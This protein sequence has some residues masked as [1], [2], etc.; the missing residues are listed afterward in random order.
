MSVIPAAY[1]FVQVNIDTSGLQPVA[2][3]SPGVI[4]IVGDTGGAGAA[5]ANTPTRVDTREDAATAFATVGPSGAVTTSTPLY[6]ALAIAMLQD[7][8]PSKIYGVRV[9]GGDYAAALAALDAA[10][11]VTFVSLAGVVAKAGAGGVDEVTLLK[12]HC[13]A[14]SAAGQRRIGVACV[15]PTIAKSA[16]YVA[17]VI[18]LAAP[19]KSDTSRL[20]LIAA[21]G[22]NDGSGGA[23]D[24]AAAAMA[25]IAGYPPHV[26]MVLKRIVGFKLPV[27]QQYSPAE[28]GQLSEAN[29]IPIIDPALIVGESL[30]FADGRCFTADANLTFIDIVRTLDDVEF[31]LKAGL[32]GA[33]GDA[34]ITRSGLVSVVTRCDGILSPLQSR[35]VI[36]GYSISIPVLDILKVPEAARTA[37]ETA[38]VAA[39][40]ANRVVDV[41]VSI[42]LGPA[43]H[44]LV[45][46]LQP[47]F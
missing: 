19:A 1:P 8:K 34:R 29:I 47:K 44:R 43:V 9:A 15:D 37:G 35:A 7:P 45:I 25:A 3:R 39:A 40:R 14:N 16:T 46:A 28:I 2:Q 12:N 32:I 20:I 31:R 26:S 11:D 42:T 30:H 6:E 36:D 22:A 13:E 33:V 18:A 24:V 23:V 38:T 17:D 21:R 27:G 41:I 10:D 5:A 4:A